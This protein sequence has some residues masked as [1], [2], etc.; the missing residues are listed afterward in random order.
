MLE[1]PAM[2]RACT[3]SWGV[4]PPQVMTYLFHKGECR[5]RLESGTP[6]H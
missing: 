1:L 3:T 4:E 2:I 6:Q 5:G